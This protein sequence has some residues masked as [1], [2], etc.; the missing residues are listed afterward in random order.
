MNLF[1][2]D[3]AIGDKRSSFQMLQ[4]LLDQIQN[5]YGGVIVLTPKILDRDQSYTLQEYYVPFY[6]NKLLF[7]RLF[8]EVTLSFIPYFSYLLKVKNKRD[9]KNVIIYS[10]S[11][12]LVFF[13][14]F[15]KFF[16]TIK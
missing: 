2:S 16:L 6:K 14:I 10:P 5:K 9:I 3:I 8:S 11:I 7:L 15:Q 4:P 13:V 12:F 1:V